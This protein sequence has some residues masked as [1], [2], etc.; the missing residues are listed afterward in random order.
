MNPY[1]PYHKVIAGANTLLGAEGLPELLL[2]YLLDLPEEGYEPPSDN[3]YPRARLARLLWYD[4]P[5]ALSGPL[6]TA[7]QKR[8]LLFDPAF[9]VVDTAELRELHPK[10]Y[11]LYAQKAVLPA[12]TAAQTVVRCFLNRI[13][14]RSSFVTA[15]G[16]RF[17][18]L[19]NTGLETRVTGSDLPLETRAFL[20]EQSI[21]EALSGVNLTGLGTVS[22]SR[23]DHSDN[24]SGLLSDSGVNVGRWVC[25]SVQWAEGEEGRC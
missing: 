6:P 19:V 11:R 7:E 21:R 8:S 23:A 18:I 16:V 20:V 15:I 2:R 12:Q 1:H 24:G 10:G 25:C 22:F 9:P 4:G 5:G 14:D 13:Y 17:E 3:R